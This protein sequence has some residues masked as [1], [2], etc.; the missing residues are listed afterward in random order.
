MQSPTDKNLIVQNRGYRE[1]VD[2]EISYNKSLTFV[3]LILNNYKIDPCDIVEQFKPL[4]KSLKKTSDE[5][6]K[7]VEE[8]VNVDTTTGQE[9]REARQKL[10]ADF[11][12]DYKSFHGCPI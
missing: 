9:L 12:G 10:M 7:N 8:A 3:D 5:L 1:M 4:I 2:T 6:L 11:F